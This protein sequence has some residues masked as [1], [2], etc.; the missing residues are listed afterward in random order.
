MTRPCS[1][2]PE[3]SRILEARGHEPACT[4]A[5][6]AT[7]RGMS[8]REAAWEY[9][10]YMGRRRFSAAVFAGLNAGALVAVTKGHSELA[11]WLLGAGI[12]TFLALQFLAYR[13]VAA[14][15]DE[16]EVRREAQQALSEQVLIAK[17]LRR[18]LLTGPQPFDFDVTEAVEG[19]VRSARDH[20]AELTP[21]Y[22]AV[23]L[24][25]P[26]GPAAD[27]EGRTGEVFA[28]AVSWLDR[29]VERLRSIV[30]RL[31]Q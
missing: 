2:L 11:P 20:M 30:S 31:A 15:I 14:V 6:S 13:D 28:P 5:S 8:S 17:A 1:S 19:W 16:R 23:F 7:L 18:S 25:D 4:G 22:V 12:V 21:E 10:Q 29:H 27:F 24:D 26:G 3:R 9:F